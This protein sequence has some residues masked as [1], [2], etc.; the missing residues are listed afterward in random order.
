[1]SRFES[2]VSAESWERLVRTLVEARD[3]DD[4][5]QEPLSDFEIAEIVRHM[6]FEVDGEEI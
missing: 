4:R 5:D 3:E 6:V 2:I 1:M